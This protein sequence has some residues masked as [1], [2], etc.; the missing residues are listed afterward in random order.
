MGCT[1]NDIMIHGTWHSRFATPSCPLASYWFVI[2]IIARKSGGGN[3]PNDL[4][5]ARQAG[6]VIW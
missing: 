6:L 3:L 2:E 4:M 1:K 5:E